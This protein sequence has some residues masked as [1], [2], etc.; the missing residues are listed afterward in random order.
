[1]EFALGGWEDVEGVYR[2]PEYFYQEE[3]AITNI[4]G[5]NFDKFIT[6][7]SDPVF[8]MVFG[9][10]CGWCK[11]MMP[12]WEKFAEEV[13]E[14]EA[15]LVVAR[16]DGFS[17]MQVVDRY[18]ARPWPSLV[19]VKEGKYYRMDTD[20]VRAVTD[21]QELHDWINNEEYLEVGDEYSGEDAGYAK[22]LRLQAAK[23]KSRKRRQE[24]E[25][26][27]EL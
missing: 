5:E 12:L 14:Q 11:T 8:V 3:T 6:E 24:R 22:F 16:M 25:A 7:T 27:G 19:L 10:K 17:N 9:P 13:K 20:Y 18:N 1:M 4:Q 21:T 15:P 2:K 23:E 26:G